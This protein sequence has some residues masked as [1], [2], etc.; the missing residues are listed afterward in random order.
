MNL[1][2]SAAGASLFA[3]AQ[4]SRQ[5]QTNTGPN[6]LPNRSTWWALCASIKSRLPAIPAHRSYQH[7]VFTKPGTQPAT[8]NSRATSVSV[9]NRQQV[10][11]FL[12]RVGCFQHI[13]Q[14]NTG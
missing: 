9:I 11:G 10:T 6:T 5:E 7:V 2:A 13:A 8:G 14:D 12:P 3:N 1:P 4:F